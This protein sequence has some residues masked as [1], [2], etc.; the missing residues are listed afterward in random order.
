[1]RSDDDGETWTFPRTLLDGPIDDRDAGVLE[2]AK[3][4][5]LVTTFTSLAYEKSFPKDEPRRS[6]WLAAHNRISEEER[7]AELGQWMIRSTDG[8]ITWSQR[9]SSIVNSPHGPIQLKD[10]RLLYAGKKTL[11]RR[12]RGRRLRV[13]RRRPDLAVARRN[14][15]PRG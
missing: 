15:D 11:R 4:I 13:P 6:R 8:G 12:K 5:L 9:Y 3:G 14:P 2:T 7:K 1:M 10:G